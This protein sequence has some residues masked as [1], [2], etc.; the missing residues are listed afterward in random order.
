M[1]PF[2]AAHLG[3]TV[4]SFHFGAFRRIWETGQAI[5]TWDPD[6]R[7]PGSL[8]SPE[9]PISLP[10]RESPS[11]TLNQSGMAQFS[12]DGSKS[13]GRLCNRVLGVGIPI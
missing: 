7:R 9:N 13:R 12:F 1:P 8:H 4:W 6:N 5:R 11:R 10:I 2:D 3:F